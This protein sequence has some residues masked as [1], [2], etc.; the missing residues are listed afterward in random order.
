MIFPGITTTRFGL[1]PSNFFIKL[2]SDNIAAS[3]S[4]LDKSN[5]NSILYYNFPFIETG[6]IYVLSCK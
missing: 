3:I 2:S 4:S 1:F 5:G 6:Y